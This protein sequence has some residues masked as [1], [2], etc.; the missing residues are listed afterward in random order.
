MHELMLSKRKAFLSQQKTHPDRMCIEKTVQ[1]V[2]KW[3]NN[4]SA[5]DIALLPV[6]ANLFDVSIDSLFS[7]NTEDDPNSPVEK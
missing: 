2:S 7:E 3:E 6:I 1:A 4:V 5:P